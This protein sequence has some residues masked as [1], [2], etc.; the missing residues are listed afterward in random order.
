MIRDRI[1][2][3]TPPCLE[4]PYPSSQ[5]GGTLVFESVTN[6][7]MHRELLSDPDGYRPACCPKCGNTVLHAHD[8]KERSVTGKKRGAPVTLRRY[9]CRQC[10]AVWRILPCFIARFLWYQ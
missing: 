7:E 6:L 2:A 10:E 9:E 3:P 5:K 1:P 8:F 4:K